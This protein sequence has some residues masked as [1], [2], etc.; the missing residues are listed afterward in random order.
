MDLKLLEK[1]DE[2]FTENPTRGTRRLSHALR[3]R[4]GL[5][6]GRDKVR[7]LMWIMGVAA[8]YPKKNLSLSNESHKKYPYLLRGVEVTRPNHAVGSAPSWFGA[9]ILHTSVAGMDLSI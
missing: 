5:E 7:R 2:L 9:R 3:K 1:L 8:I 6:A 4:F